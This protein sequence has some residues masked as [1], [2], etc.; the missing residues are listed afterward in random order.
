MA[1]ALP[2]PEINPYAPPRVFD[3]PVKPDPGVGV[4][5]DGNLLVVHRDALLPP[6]CVKSGQPAAEWVEVPVSFV[7]FSTLSRIKFTLRAPLS[8]RSMWWRSNGPRISLVVAAIAFA[9]VPLLLS[10]VQSAYEPPYR[11]PLL[12]RPYGS[13]LVGAVAVGLI[14]VLHALS[15]WRLLEFQRFQR[16]YF[17][18]T[19][20]HRRFLE[21]LPPWPGID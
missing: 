17:W 2:T 9:C 12:E 13:V 19:G 1:D 6:V 18:F 14:A 8:A 3:P 7:D 10:L 16:D 11:T 15:Y 21:Q 5:R 20:A 4:W